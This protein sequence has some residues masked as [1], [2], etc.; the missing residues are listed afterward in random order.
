MRKTEIQKD[1]SLI[2]NL[3]GF[4]RFPLFIKNNNIKIK[5]CNFIIIGVPCDITCSGKSGSKLAPNKIR[6]AS[7]NL[8]WEKHKWPWNFQLKKYLKVIDAGDLIYKF[9]NIKDL[10]K[11]IKKKIFSFL[12]FKKKIM[13]FGGDHYITLPI[14]RTYKIFYKEISLIH[15]D[16]HTDTYYNN[17]EFDHGS[18]FFQ[19]QKEKLISIENTIQLGIRTFINKENNFKIL[20][21]QD[22][23]TKKTKNI[24]KIIEETVNNKPTYI[25]FDIDCIDPAYAPGTGTPVI[26]GIN[27]N[28]ILEI[29]RLLKN[30]NIIGIDIVEVS[31]L[32]DIADI[33]SLT[34]ATIALELLYLEAYKYFKLKINP[35]NV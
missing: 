10:N 22:I 26:A 25:S 27:T 24:I 4:M 15:F 2:S 20:T 30:I 23:N 12:K 11:Q 33:T 8:I 13:V 32:Q 21:S 7:G 5:D 17:N 14:L 16:A 29:I 34:A 28:K 9:G 31:P 18:I 1:Q 35:K 6:E 3:F 19:A